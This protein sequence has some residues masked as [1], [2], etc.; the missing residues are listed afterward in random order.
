M[1]SVGGTSQACVRH[2]LGSQALCRR[3]RAA[4]LAPGHLP[5]A[6]RQR[7]R[8]CEQSAAPGSPGTHQTCRTGMSWP[9]ARPMC[10]T[11]GQRRR[12]SAMQST[13]A[14]GRAERAHVLRVSRL[15]AAQSPR[16]CPSQCHQAVA[17][18]ARERGRR[19]CRSAPAAAV[20]LRP[21]S[22]P[23]QTGPRAPPR[24]G[25][26]RAP[27]SVN[28]Q[29]ARTCTRLTSPQSERTHVL[30]L[31]R[32]IASSPGMPGVSSTPAFM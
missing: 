9:L 17:R 15:L 30:S 22:G 13:W 21:P 11:V 12:I 24:A 20:R 29:A 3:S 6:L 10:R 32:W 14:C 31:C 28:N 19:R 26:G 7:K 5:A 2:A 23:H 4:A 27:Q 16:V 25:A 18:A 1:Q 8:A